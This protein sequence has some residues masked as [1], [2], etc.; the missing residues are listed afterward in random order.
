MP[1]L[2]ETVYVTHFLR[3][4]GIIKL[5]LYLKCEIKLEKTH[6]FLFEIVSLSIALA[7]ITFCMKRIKIQFCVLPIIFLLAKS[8]KHNENQPCGYQF[9]VNKT[10]CMEVQVS[11]K[12]SGMACTCNFWLLGN[13]VG[14]PSV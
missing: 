2:Y 10:K 11:W 1:G 4:G 5:L 14:V 7:M 8:L 3:G 9:N 6:I 12:V 13:T